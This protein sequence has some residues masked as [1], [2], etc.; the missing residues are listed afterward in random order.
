M[1]L[2]LWIA[3]AIVS[4]FIGVL[5]T[6]LFQDRVSVVLVKI[7]RG[8]WGDGGRRTLSGDWYTFYSV[9]PESGTSLSASSTKGSVEIIRLR[10]VGS[11]VAGVNAIKSRNYIIWAVLKDSSC[12]TGTWRNSIDGR[13]NWGG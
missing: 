5:L 2:L 13:Y 10:N 11:R 7:L 4:A 3:G 9:S 12:L 8:F 6:V 1:S